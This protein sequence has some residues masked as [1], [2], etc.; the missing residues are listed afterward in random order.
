MINF[1]LEFV[2]PSSSNAEE[3]EAAFVERSADGVAK[4]AH[5]LKSSARSVGANDMADLCQTL[6]S[7]G[8]SED[9]DVI[10]PEAPRVSSTTQEVLEYINAL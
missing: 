6:E 8:N 9:W 5:K 7:A 2:E 4:A 3:I 10:D 1:L